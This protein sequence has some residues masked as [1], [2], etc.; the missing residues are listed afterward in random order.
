MGE[1]HNRGYRPAGDKVPVFQL[2]R[3]RNRGFLMLEMTFALAIAVFVILSAL[4][5]MISA[6]AASNVARQNT[7]AYNAARQVV[8]NVRLYKGAKL[9]NNSYSNVTVF[10][11]VPQL[12]QL[13][14]GAASM[15]IA[16]WRAPIKQVT[17][18][19]TWRAGDKGGKARSKT[20]VALV[21]PKGVTP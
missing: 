14:G 18:N 12:A 21:S 7:I 20:L 3:R 17:V 1:F 15:T 19:V 16:T 10:G 11:P 5:F 9:A 4:S 2:P 6:A 13:T 8:E